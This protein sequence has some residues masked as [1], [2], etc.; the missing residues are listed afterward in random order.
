MA[1]VSL[2]GYKIKKI[3]MINAI[4]QQ[5]ELKITNSFGFNVAYTPEDTKAIA[6]LTETLQMADRPEEFHIELTLEGVFDLT[7]IVDVE[8]KK[9][10][11][12]MCYDS[13]FPYANQIVTQLASNSGMSGLMLKKIPMKRENIQFGKNPVGD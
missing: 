11:H 1:E 5:G 9:D 10:A 12:L 2:V 4:K 8:T 7:G 6:E 13:L 3:D